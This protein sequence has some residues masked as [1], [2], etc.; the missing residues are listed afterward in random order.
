M[1]LMVIIVSSSASTVPVVRDGRS[2]VQFP[3]GVNNF[4]Q[5]GSGGR[6]VCLLKNTTDSFPGGKAEGL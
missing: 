4:V 3:V 2:G 5:I 1:L 6:P